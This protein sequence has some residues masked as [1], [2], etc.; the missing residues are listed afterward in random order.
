[1]NGV[2]GMTNLVLATQLTDEQREYVETA[3]LSADFL[4]TV[5]N[6]ILDFS[7]IEAGRLD[8]NPVDFSLKDCLE[9]TGACSVC[10][11]RTRSWTIPCRSRTTFP[12]G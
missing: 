7:K 4:L 6:D 12:T 8:L 2:L 11:S 5:L 10:R 3:R 9:Q 1:M